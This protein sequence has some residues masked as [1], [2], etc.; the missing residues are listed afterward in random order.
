VPTVIPL[1]F[2][3]LFATMSGF[4]PVPFLRALS[5]HESSLN[6]N[7][8]T[9]SSNATGLFQ[10]VATVLKDYNLQHGTKYTLDDTKDPALNSKIGIGLITR[11]VKSYQK[12]H[13]DSLGMDWK[14]PRYVELVVQGF[15]AGYSEAGGVGFVVGQME[16]LGIPAERITVDTVSEAAKQL[17]VSRFLSVPERVK[18]AKAVSRT[19]FEQLARDEAKAKAKK[20]YSSNV[21]K[22]PFV[23]APNE[24][25][26][27][28]DSALPVVASVLLSSHDSVEGSRPATVE[29]TLGNTILFLSFPFIPLAGVAL[30]RMLTKRRVA[31]AAFI[32]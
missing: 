31:K 9:K 21:D 32:I 20:S 12:N 6:P 4:V 24:S 19:Y 18:Y 10:V 27:S 5:Y 22:H 11:I 13:P 29:N 28:G 23:K 8:V 14:S 2:D 30:A 25:L 3:T 15:N 16:K 26:P 17:K 1:L 7:A